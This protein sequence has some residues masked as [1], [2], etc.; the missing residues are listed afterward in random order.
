MRKIEIDMLKAIDRQRDWTG[1]NTSVTVES[2]G[3]TTV[4]LFSNVIAVFS[5]YDL[6]LSHAG[7]KTVTTKSRLNAILSRYKLG[8]IYQKNFKWYFI[9][10]NDNIKPWLGTHRLTF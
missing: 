8:H 10:H 6:I 7:Y 3:I 9:D 1:R 2:T 4:R 5:G